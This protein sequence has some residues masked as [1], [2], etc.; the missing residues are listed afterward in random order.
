[1]NRR[2]FLKASLAFLGSMGLIGAGGLIDAHAI[3]PYSIE[4][5]TFDLNPHAPEAPTTPP[6][7]CAFLSDFHRSAATPAKIIAA[8]VNRCRAQNPD[9]IL[10]GGDFI[11]D[12]V[13][14]A[15]ECAEILG[16]LSAPG[17]VY[18][19]LGNHDYWHGG[20][21]V[22]HALLKAG[23]ED[24][25]NRNT[26]ISGRLSLCGIDDHWAGSP[27]VESAFRGTGKRVRLSCSHNPLIFPSVR[28]MKT[29]LLCGHTHGGQINIPFVQNPYLRSWKTYIRG[30]FHEGNSAMYVNRGIGMLTLPFRLGARP[31][32]TIVNV[33]A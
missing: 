21:Q 27:D 31:E 1:M 4:I 29:T 32:I 13:S 33:H 22:R 30:W 6:V 25:T 28:E 23:F 26:K 15:A 2:K 24:L 9:V 20:K 16:G 10:L 17:G 18:F 8:A 3:E 19:V 11:S 5:S 14:L 12:E 7:R